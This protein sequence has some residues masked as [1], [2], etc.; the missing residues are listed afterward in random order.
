MFLVK[1]HQDIIFYGILDAFASK[2]YDRRA[3]LCTPAMVRL[4][5]GDPKSRHLKYGLR[6]Q[7]QAGHQT[8][9]TKVPA[10]L[11]VKIAPQ[12]TVNAAGNIKVDGGIGVVVYPV[13]TVIAIIA[14]RLVI[15]QVSFPERDSQP[16]VGAESVVEWVGQSG[17][18]RDP[19]TFSVF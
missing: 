13:I 3:Y 12:F 6:G 5:S 4:E 9:G 19:G 7:T 16:Q 17:I 15:L 14:L 10:K 8:Q 1:N 11:Q 18:Y 2:K